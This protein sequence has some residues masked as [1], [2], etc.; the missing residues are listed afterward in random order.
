MRAMDHILLTVLTLVV[1]AAVGL[2]GLWFHD[3]AARMEALASG[4]QMETQRA[5]EQDAATQRALAK[6]A[7]LTKQ[8]DYEEGLLAAAIRDR[9]AIVGMTKVEVRMAKGDPYIVQRGDG[10]Q[11]MYR[12]VGGV[13]NWI[14][15][16]SEDDVRGVLFGVDGLVIHSRDVAGKPIVGNAIRQ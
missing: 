1:L 15:R 9:R 10:L 12:K 3:R 4:R 5:K 7:A 8:I 13:E 11:D 2:I 16:Y 14:Y 6:V